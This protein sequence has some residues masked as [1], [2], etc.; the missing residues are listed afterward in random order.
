[1]GLYEDLQEQGHVVD[2]EHG[3]AKDRTEVWVNECTL[4][5]VRIQWYALEEE[6]E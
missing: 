4:R 6:V 5:A 3:D 2:H 1:M